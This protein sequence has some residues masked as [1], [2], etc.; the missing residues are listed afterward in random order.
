MF[1][2]CLLGN[3]K[4][5]VSSWGRSHL[6]LSEL[7]PGPQANEYVKVEKETAP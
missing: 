2:L 7:F 1:I 3:Q 6:G 4:Q 5:N